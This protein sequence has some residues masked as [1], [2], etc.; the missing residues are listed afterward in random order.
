MR[1]GK[2]RWDFDDYLVI[3][4]WSEGWRNEEREEEEEDGSGLEGHGGDG[5]VELDWRENPTQHKSVTRREREK[6]NRRKTI[7]VINVVEDWRVEKK[8]RFYG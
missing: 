8:V 5:W 6:L 2:K 3:W 7:I 4:F 1:S